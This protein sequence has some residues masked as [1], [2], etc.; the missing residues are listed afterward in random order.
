MMTHFDRIQKIT[1]T[2]IVEWRA[3]LAAQALLITGCILSLMLQQFLYVAEGEGA[4]TRSRIWWELILNMQLLS[5]GM[6]WFYYSDRISDATGRRRTFYI[7][8][9]FFA[10]I[11]VSVPSLLGAI[12]AFNN[13]FQI[14]PEPHVLYNFGLFA[15]AYWFGG[16][17]LHGQISLGQAG[18]QR[19]KGKRARR[20]GPKVWFFVPLQILLLVI[21]LDAATGGT[22]WVMYV[23]LLLSLQAAVPYLMKSVR[24]KPD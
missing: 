15:I 12:A 1:Q 6:M 22:D 4:F 9:C 3:I 5:M 2:S 7:V 10:V 8:R 16:L 11:T 13:W 21:V 18:R 24:F 17:F 20:K 23:P 14:K 19:L